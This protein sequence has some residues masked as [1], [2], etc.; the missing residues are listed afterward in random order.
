MEDFD[1]GSLKK[2]RQPYKKPEKK[3]SPDIKAEVSKMERRLNVK[4]SMA[5]RRMAEMVKTFKQS[6]RDIWK[7]IYPTLVKMWGASNGI[8]RKIA[9]LD[10]M[11]EKNGRNT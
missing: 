2:N 4:I 7:E 9:M 3:K 11:L 1:F 5:E 6:A 10:M 8:G